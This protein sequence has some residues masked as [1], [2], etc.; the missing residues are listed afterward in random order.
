MSTA[1]FPPSASYA[2]AL[3]RISLGFI[4]IWAFF[5]KL[6]GLG[7]STC[8]DT[9]NNAINILCDKAWLSGG[10]PTAG[11]L[12]FG[13]SGPLADFYQSLAGIAIID[14]MFMIG[15][16][17]IGI[18]LIFGIAVKL[19]SIAGIAMMLLMWSAA[20]W[21]ANHPILD[22]HIIYAL[23][24]IIIATTDQYQVLGLGKWW[25]SKVPA[26]LQ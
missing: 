13:T 10:S 4:F 19:A 11:F 16:A 18:G 5:D 15:L 2:I 14:W 25:K 9:T 6:F 1:T 8:R 26:I 22:D 7:F 17:G 3:T 21:P 20:L 24:L 12:K 23:V